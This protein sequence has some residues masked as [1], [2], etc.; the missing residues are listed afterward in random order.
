VSYGGSSLLAMFIC[1]GLL[2][3]VAWH[4]YADDDWALNSARFK[5][6][7]TQLVLF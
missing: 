2:G 7:A 1:V 4:S 5:P 3:S 6:A